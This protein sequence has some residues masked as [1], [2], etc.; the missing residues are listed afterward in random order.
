[1]FNRSFLYLVIV[2]TLLFSGCFITGRVVYENGE[3]VDNVTV[4][5]NGDQSRVVTTDKEGKYRFGELSIFDFISA[6]SYTVTPSKAGYGFKPV[7]ANVTMINQTLGDLEDIPGPETDVVFEVDE[8]MVPSPT[9]EGPITGGSGSPWINATRFDLSEVGY[10]QKEY[11]ISGTAR[12]YT[13]I[14][15]LDSDGLWQAAPVNSEPYKTRILVHRPIDPQ[16]FNGSV[17]VEWF[18][19]SSG[20]EAAPDWTMTHTELIRKGYAW[21]GVSAQYVG[22]EG[23]E[24]LVSI[25]GMGGLNLKSYDPARYGSLNHP[26]DSFSYDI[27]SQAGQAVRNPAGVDPMDGLTPET[28]IAIGES[29]S[30]SRLMTYVNAIDPLVGI[31]DGF[32]IHSRY[33]GSAALSQAPQPDIDTP[34]VV[35]IRDDIRV[36]VLIF[37]TESDLIGL[38]GFPDRQPDGPNFRLWEVAGTAHYDAYGLLFGPGDLGDDPAVAEVQVTATPIPGIIECES[39]INS[40]PQHFVVKAALAALNGWIRNGEAPPSAPRLEIAGSPPEFVLDAFGNVLGGIRTPYVDVPI[41]TFSGLGQGGQ[42]FCFLFGTTVPF[43]VDSLAALYPDHDTYV[44]A[45]NE[46]TDL[47]VEGGFIL[48]SD[49]QLIKTAAAASDIGVGN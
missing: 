24:G 48:D 28:L 14:G 44:S 38:G 32:L 33:A 47:A 42:G 13:N 7:S 12:A 49:A 9:V 29:Q 16:A 37:L 31:Y 19:V 36:P 40:G 10:S 17:V 35:R 4:T 34:A 20:L 5:L 8:K 22:V 27:F 21:V 3:G 2:S 11:F 26:G 25:P 41:A 43:D 45:V 1:M 30:A 6:G 15:D 46:A 39:P 23:G 18:N